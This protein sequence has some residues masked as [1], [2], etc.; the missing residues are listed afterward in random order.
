MGQ[1][2]IIDAFY[3]SCC[4]GATSNNEDVWKG[5]EPIPYL[6]EQDDSNSQY[7]FCQ[8]S[9]DYE[10]RF[11]IGKR[12][13]GDILAE[14]LGQGQIL[15][16]FWDLKIKERAPAER[17][18]KFIVLFENKSLDISGEEFYL[19]LGKSVGWHRFKSTRFFI[20]KIKGGY[21]FTGRELGHGVG[22]CQWGA[23]GRAEKG[24]NYK[25]ILYH[26]FPNTEIERR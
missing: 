19:M 11:K 9:P 20:H 21:Y 25:E 16:A 1:S 15:G 23:K 17:V 18:K 26:Y 12:E 2:K 8:Q 7:D 13:L 22:L 4:G 6:R 5:S 14:R 10:G 3:H 24:H